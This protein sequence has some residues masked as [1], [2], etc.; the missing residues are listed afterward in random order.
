MLESYHCGPSMDWY[1]TVEELFGV[2]E[3]SVYATPSEEAP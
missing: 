3:E 2:V 1:E